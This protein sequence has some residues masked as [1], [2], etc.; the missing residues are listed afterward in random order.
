MQNNN[1]KTKLELARRELLDLGLRGNPLLH[2]PKNKRFLEIVDE[3]ST[4]IV[5]ILVEE[6]KVMRFLPIPEAYER[7]G[8]GSDDEQWEEQEPLPLLE[9]YLEQERG[10]ERFSDFYLQTRLSSHELDT[11]LIKLENEAYTLLQEQGIEVLYLALGFLE[12]Y[13][14][15]SSHTPRYAPLILLPVELLRESARARFTLSFTN[16]ELGG[17]LALAARLKQDFRLTLPEFGEEVVLE[18]YF[19]QV[20]Q[21]AANR[22]RWKVHCNQIRLGLFSFGKFQ[23]YTDLDP[24]NWPDSHD[25][26]SH[27]QL[28][29]LFEVGYREDAKLLKA[30][31]NHEL[32]KAPES[33]HLVK[34][35]DSSQLKA[36]LAVLEGASLVVQGPPG[37]GKSQ[38][39]SNIIGEALARG[40]KVLFVAQKMAALEVVKSRLDECHLG[41]AVL[42]LH[43][44]KSN[45]KA[46][47]E[48]LRQVFDNGRPKV[49]DRS[50]E[51]QRLVELRESLD[52]YV[53]ELQA[54]ILASQTDYVTALGRML[55]LLS[56]DRL[57]ALARMDFQ[58]LRDWGPEELARGQ[59]AMKSMEDYLA[60]YGPP[61]KNPYCHSRRRV[62]S[63]GEEQELC[64][65]VQRSACQLAELTDNVIALAKT[66]QLPIPQSFD[67]IAILQRAG[68]RALNAPHLA[69][70]KVNTEQW[71]ARRDEVQQAIAAGQ[72]LSRTR[73]TMGRAS[74]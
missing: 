52:G 12:W 63:P 57:Q 31:S 36:I 18:D 27:P 9:E 40:K 44:H 67:D 61:S 71:Q 19:D 1:L 69:G 68:K 56:D 41:D 3:R 30:S 46:V 58:Y 11:R 23:M 34:D 54:P 20:Q 55:V 28:E 65:L 66:M 10:A 60:E 5:N 29:K 14:D 2:V 15:E 4:E 62:L 74:C 16:A 64:G 43:S 39:I 51:Y 48:S 53:E 22:P 37:T 24:D 59:R 73:T 72:G 70:V 49:P 47:L 8:A 7:E 26:L 35:A 33:L 50:Q 38:T 25:L 32:L 45:K 6:K 21:M 42:E 17:N 13:E